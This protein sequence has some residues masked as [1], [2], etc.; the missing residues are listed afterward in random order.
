MVVCL[1]SVCEEVAIPPATE[2]IKQ[3]VSSWE[4]RGGRDSPRV[5]IFPRPAYPKYIHAPSP[6]V[7]IEEIIEETVTSEERD[8][9]GMYTP[10]V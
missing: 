3:S 4:R 8:V 5:P 10:C 1:V 9:M 7:I 6:N 2:H